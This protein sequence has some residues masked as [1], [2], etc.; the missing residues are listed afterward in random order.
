M[1]NWLSFS[2]KGP[3]YFLEEI[4][5]L[6]KGKFKLFIG[7]APGVGKTY[8][9][10]QEAHELKREGE[11]VVIGLI[12]THG[13]KETGQ[14]VGSLEVIPLKK[15]TYR[16]KEF[17][18]LDVDAVLRRKPDVVLIDELA[19]TNI[20]GSKNKKR[21]Q[22][23]L[24][25]LDAGISVYSAVN[26]QHVESLHDHVQ[27]ISGIGVR[28]RIPD[29]VL[30][31]ADEIILVDI[32]PET[33]QKRM[34]EGKIYDKTKVKQAIT[35]FF[36]LQKLAALRELSLREIANNIDDRIVK[37]MEK[38]G[39]SGP[40]WANEKILVCIGYDS[41][42]EILM[43]RGWRMASRLKARLYILTV[44]NS[45]VDS[46]HLQRINAWKELADQFD[47]VFIQ[48]PK[49]KKIARIITE[50][51]KELGVT[52]II[53]GQSARTR[54]EEIMKGSIVNAIMRESD[55]IDIHIVS[56]TR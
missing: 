34:K 47:A 51:A 44:T 23:I 30:Q 37:Q 45:H 53:L 10:L 19:H 18:E 11:D 46:K 39:V 20:P 27:Q 29:T 32:S 48:K 41:T 13:R 9:M 3:E 38:S 14:M 8:R 17:D 54:K 43:R 56:K 26:I 55:H 28:E 52:N 36:T 5:S 25:V 50:T 40:T 2:G 4:K 1:E 49:D 31:L 42:A 21:F 12:E 16:Q 35:N 24:E 33:L 6:R 22:D 7:S 15:M